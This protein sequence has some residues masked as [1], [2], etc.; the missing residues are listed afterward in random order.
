VEQALVRLDTHLKDL[1]TRLETGFIPP[2]EVLT[3]EAQRARQEV[4][5]I[6]A[7][8]ASELA[9]AELRR[10]TDLAPEARVQ[11]TTPL[12]APE[13]LTAR[14][15]DQIARAREARPERMALAGRIEAAEARLQAAGSTA[16]PTVALAGGV[17]YGRPNP[18]LFPRTN[19]WRDSWDISVTASWLLW[20]SGRRAAEV[21][22]ASAS[23]RALRARL[24]EFDSL[25]ALEIRQRRL[26]VDA[27]VA[28]ARAA[29]EGVRSAA[30]A[31]RVVDERFAAGVAT[32]TDMLDAQVALLQ[33][34]L[35]RTRALA[36][37]RIA[38][39][40]LA[41]ALGR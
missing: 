26:D 28:A 25:I 11:L 1:R 27:G 30:E 20:D 16:R 41:R 34:E 22:E 13:A 15:D 9:L 29:A 37:A 5:V 23:E 40:R 17:D 35:D 12:A 4:Q 24:D 32:S 31:R 6:E 8:N 33:A 10:L 36:S 39:A 7:R 19:E 18:R 2:N 3:A 14:L 21:G 38:E